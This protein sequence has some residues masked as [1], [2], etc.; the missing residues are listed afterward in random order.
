MTLLAVLMTA[1]T[2]LA[3]NLAEGACKN[4][5]WWITTTGVL[6]VKINGK[7]ADYKETEYE[8]DS[9]GTTKVTTA[10]WGPYWKKIKSIYVEN[11]CTS[12]GNDAFEGL[13][14]VESI[15]APSVEYVT[16]YAF[17]RCGVPG[18]NIHLPKVKEV[19]GKGFK[20]CPAGT[21]SMPVVEEV[22][23]EAFSSCYYLTRVDLGSKIESIGTMAFLCCPSM[24]ID[25]QPS[26]FISNP[27]PPTW[28]TKLDWTWS[29]VLSN[30]GLWSARILM[31]IISGVGAVFTEFFFFQNENTGW[32]DVN[33]TD[34]T[35]WQEYFSGAYY[36]DDLEIDRSKT[37]YM[38]PFYPEPHGHP[39]GGVPVVCVPE[40]LLQTY[41]NTYDNEGYV[42]RSSGFGSGKLMAGEPMAHDGL[43]GYWMVDPVNNISDDVYIG[44]AGAMNSEKRKAIL[45]NKAKEIVNRK[46]NSV[47]IVGATQIA[48]AAFKDMTNVYSFHLGGTVR[49]IGANAFENACTGQSATPYFKGAEALE[50]IGKE[51]FKGSSITDIGETPNLT[52]IGDYAFQGSKLYY[53][54]DLKA[55][56]SMGKYAFSNTQVREANIPGKTNGK[57]LPE[58]TFMGCTQLKKVSFDSGYSMPKIGTKAFA[59][60]AINNIFVSD[61]CPETATDAF[62]GITL[63]TIELHVK[64]AYVQSYENNNVWNKMTKNMEFTYPVSLSGN[65]CNGQLNSDGTL[66]VESNASQNSSNAEDYPW[67]NYREYVKHIVV[68]ASKVGQNAFNWPAADSQVETI[69]FS[70]SGKT[71]EANAFR[72]HTKLTT[73][74]LEGVKYIGDNAFERCTGLTKVTLDDAETIGNDAFYGCTALKRVRFGEKLRELG[75][76][77]LYNDNNIERID[78][79]A[80]TPP[81]AQTNSLYTGNNQHSIKLYVPTSSIALYVQADA[82]KNF[83]YA[84]VSAEHGDVVFSR[85]FYDGYYLLF[86]DGTLL[87]SASKAEGNYAEAL[88]Q[89]YKEQVKHIE[90]TG[91]IERLSSEFADLPNLETVKLTPSLATLW[92]SF[93]NCPKLRSINLGN[94]V[95]MF[96]SGSGYGTFEG[97]TSLTDVD[98]SNVKSLMGPI[99]KG[100]TGLTA[101][102]LPRLEY[103]NDAVFDGCTGLESVDLGRAEFTTGTEGYTFRGC[104]KLKTARYNG[105]L[106]DKHVFDD[107]TALEEVH[108]GEHV[109]DLYP[110]FFNTGLKRIYLNTPRPIVSLDYYSWNGIAALDELDRKNITLYVPAQAVS[111][112]KAADKWKDFQVK[113]DPTLPEDLIP[114]GGLIGDNGVWHLDANGRLVIDCDGEMD[115]GFIY[116][117]QSPFYNY[118][119]FIKEIVVGNFTTKLAYN[120]FNNCTWG[121]NPTKLTLGHALQDMTGGGLYAM[122]KTLKDVYCYAEVPPMVNSTTFNWYQVKNVKLHVLKQGGVK[123]L[124]QADTY[125]QKFDIVADLS[126]TATGIETAETTADDAPTRWYTLDGLRIERPTKPGLYILNGKK[127]AIK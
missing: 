57:Q 59:G 117:Y 56:T 48:D 106:L 39:D 54:P 72:N 40:N 121:T 21:I 73:L 4:G 77:V 126:Y 84:G 11:G 91:T 13:E 45:N 76:W 8:T 25:N 17:E 10:P 113:A 49:K 75:S 109:Q 51:A 37:Q 107:C 104:T 19:D 92:D 63:S 66:T 28:K 87:A 70:G 68:K 115:E 47:Y 95:Y 27:T 55:V 22:G 97:C 64:P 43:Q 5:T 105:Q 12:L 86:S 29:G 42:S 74:D 79:E 26:I 41:I 111:L 2:A 53:H 85:K 101:V 103:I 125:W 119:P 93:F 83:T 65:G 71:I 116:H 60:S 3:A 108:L 99:F 102:E 50:E 110:T 112:Y 96:S 62:Q 100:C 46:H 90:I 24:W 89:S 61:N 94:V 30:I 88:W 9:Y 58:G 82:F 18:I 69:V 44:A 122:T 67:Y 1:T 124:Y 52:T 78:I 120:T 15:S 38:N 81:T 36:S 20:D 6:H 123:E 127:V 34:L 23:R 7:M 33:N 35:D 32:Y 16:S 80:T 14:Y 98:L 114:A 118:S 31:D